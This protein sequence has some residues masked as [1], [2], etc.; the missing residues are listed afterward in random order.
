MKAVIELTIR[1]VVDAPEENPQFYIEEH[2]CLDNHVEQ[3]RLECESRPGF[4]NTCFRGEAKYL[5]PA[6]EQDLKDLIPQFPGSHLA[7]T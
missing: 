7:S 1:M 3:L 5:R 4:C 6:T 2:Y